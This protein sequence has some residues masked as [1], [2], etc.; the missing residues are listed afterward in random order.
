[1]PSPLTGDST[2]TINHETMVLSIQHYLETLV[3]AD[4]ACPTV[5]SVEAA[6]DPY[7][8]RTGFVITLDGNEKSSTQKDA[9]T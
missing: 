1:M 2:L 5:E 3:F 7:G 9:A 4:G 8:N 6:K